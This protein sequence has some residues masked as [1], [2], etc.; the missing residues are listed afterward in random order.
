MSKQSQA[1]VLATLSGGSPREPKKRPTAPLIFE[2]DME[3]DIVFPPPHDSSSSLP[4]PPELEILPASVSPPQPE[5]VQLPL[6]SVPPISPPLSDPD[7]PLQ[8]GPEARLRLRTRPKTL[9]MHVKE[10]R[11]PERQNEDGPVQTSHSMMCYLP[12]ST[13]D[14]L[15]WK[16]NTPPYSEKPQ[17]MVDLMESLFQTYCQ[18]WE[19]CQQLLHTLFN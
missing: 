10:T 15:N 8:H 17:A 6:Q 14:L 13:T 9:G 4:P 5:S 11:E 18:T 12:F 19:D 1:K 3:E 16:H 7:H 2:G